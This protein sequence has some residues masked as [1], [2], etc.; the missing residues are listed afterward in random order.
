MK[1]IIILFAL[2]LKMGISMAQAPNLINYQAVARNSTGSILA[3]KTIAL[4]LS[5]LNGS[6]A[7]PVQYSETRLVVTNGSGLFN[8]AIGAPGAL[9]TT[10]A[11][12]AITW[13]TGAK[14][15]KVEMDPNGGAAFVNMGAQQ[16]VS[17]PYAEHADQA[18]SLLSTAK[19]NPNQLNTAGAGSGQVLGF[20]GTSWAPTSLPGASLVLPFVGNSSSAIGQTMITLNQ[21]GIGTG[22]KS[23]SS[24]S[25]A[26][27]A[28][29]NLS[30]AVLANTL[31]GKAMEANSSSGTSVYASSTTGTAVYAKSISGRALDVAGNVKISGGNTNPG[32]GKVLTSDASGNA[33]WK[34]N[35]IAFSA[36]AAGSGFALYTIPHD[37]ETKLGLYTEEYDYGNVFTPSPTSTT[38]PGVF[39]APKAGLYHFDSYVKMTGMDIAFA[40]LTFKRLATYIRIVSID[41]TT[42]VIWGVGTSILDGEIYADLMAGGDVKLKAGDKV[43]TCVSQKND[44]L[45]A[46]IINQV[47]FSGHLVFED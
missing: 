19:I 18:G 42:R 30:T 2:L 9:N 11:Y 7:G 3:N 4:R 29:S 31:T 20:N 34:D 22:L 33:V 41:G 27:D 6:N 45:K 43:Y 28:T 39:T 14:F 32:T 16:L 24:N 15:L 1:K 26:I 12:T 46:A 35:K 37:S 21:T 5:V 17:V 10:G 47:K 13:A 8:I 44:Y 25:Y 38:T 40:T 23:T 36:T